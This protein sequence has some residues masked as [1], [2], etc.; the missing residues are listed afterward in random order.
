MMKSLTSF[1]FHL[2]LG[3]NVSAAF[4]RSAE[5][6]NYKLIFTSYF[7]EGNFMTKLIFMVGL[8]FEMGFN[9]KTGE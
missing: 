2:S 5:K 6:Y 7:V 9:T 4:R 3:K 1:D 8:Q